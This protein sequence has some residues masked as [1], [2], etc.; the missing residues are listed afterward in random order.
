[1][2]RIDGPGIRAELDA[3][4]VSYLTVSET[5]VGD[6]HVVVCLHGNAGRTQQIEA[7][8]ILRGLDGVRSVEVSPASWTILVVRFVA[9]PDE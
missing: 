8:R 3:Q 4:G 6:R 1:M 2:A 7:L 9:E 5:E